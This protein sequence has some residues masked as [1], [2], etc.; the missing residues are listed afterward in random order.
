MVPKPKNDPV[1]VT[2]STN[3]DI[4]ISSSAASGVVKAS[5]S[6]K[7]VQLAVGETLTVTS[8]VSGLDKIQLVS[9]SG[10]GVSGNQYT[11]PDIASDTLT[12]YVMASGNPIN[13]TVGEHGEVQFF[14]D[15]GL[16][17][18]IVSSNIPTGQPVYI[19][20]KPDTGYEKNTF[21]VTD[22]VGGAAETVTGSGTA[23]DPYVV[24][25]PQGGINVTTTFKA[26]SMKINLRILDKSNIGK[27]ISTA[28]GLTET[29]K[30]KV[31]GTEVTY[32][33][34]QIIDTETAQKLVF[35]SN[36]SSHKIDSVKS[37]KDSDVKTGTKL[38]STNYTV[39][40]NEKYL[41]VFVN[42]AVSATSFSSSSI[43]SFSAAPEAAEGNTENE[44]ITQDEAGITDEAATTDAAEAT[45]EVEIPD[46]PKIESESDASGDTSADETE[47]TAPAEETSS[48]EG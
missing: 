30:I 8:N 14:A 15:S 6:P 21:K 11:V 44:G 32:K 27:D 24:S 26:K 35:P 19:V 12:V 40:G 13:S 43:M 46:Y 39:V 33:D 34:K 23:S 47:V 16:T 2:I 3:K 42:T 1:T 25:M 20:L 17:T 41:V 37:Y 18:P 36:A 5:E 31:N 10:K 29:V 48:T 28:T 4:A 22:I 7:T 9:G 38:T 45:D